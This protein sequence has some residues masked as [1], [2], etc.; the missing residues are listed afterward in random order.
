MLRRLYFGVGHNVENEKIIRRKI[1]REINDGR[2]M[3]N[4]EN[5]R[6]T[7]PE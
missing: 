2:R 7:N 6:T 5:G 4:I 1:L 3:K